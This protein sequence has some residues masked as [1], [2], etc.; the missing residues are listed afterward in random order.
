MRPLYWQERLAQVPLE[1]WA[2]VHACGQPYGLFLSLRPDSIFWRGYVLP[3]ARMNQ[4][5]LQARW[6]ADVLAE[7]FGQYGERQLVE[8]QERL[9]TILAQRLD[10]MVEAIQPA[11]NGRPVER[12]RRLSGPQLY[13]VAKLQ[14]RRR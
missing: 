1:A 5:L 9:M 4:D 8:A 3:G 2:F 6:S 12:E 13:Q 11:R 14:P 10:V 7:H